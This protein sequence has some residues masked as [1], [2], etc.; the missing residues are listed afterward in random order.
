M[1]SPASVAEAVLYA[2]TQPDN[3]NVDELRISRS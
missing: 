3:V 2:L 1:M